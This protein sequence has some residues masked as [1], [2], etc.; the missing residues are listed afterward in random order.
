MERG[1]EKREGEAGRG[2]EPR[3]CSDALRGQTKRRSNEFQFTCVGIFRLMAPPRGGGEQALRSIL[4]LDLGRVR[5]VG[6]L[7]VRVG[8]GS[9]RGWGVGWRASTEKAVG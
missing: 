9:G 4:D 6:R 3:G 1:G 5:M 2:G 7:G 8:R